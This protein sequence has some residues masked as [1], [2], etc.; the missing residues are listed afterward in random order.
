[1]KRDHS[2]ALQSALDTA[3]RPLAGD[4]DLDPIIER[5]GDRRLV[6]L[7]EASHGTSEFY[8]WRARLTKRLIEEK[9]FDF[10]AAEGDWPDCWEV[11]RYVRDMPGAGRSAQDVLHAFHRWPT[12]MWANR[13]VVEF[14]E[15]L[16]T[17][18]DG[19]P[20]DRR[21]GFFGLDVYSLWDSMEAVLG[22]LEGVDPDAAERARNAYGCFD[23]YSEDVQEYAFAAQYVPTR[24]EE[25]VVSILGELRAK[26]TRYLAEAMSATAPRYPAASSSLHADLARCN[27][28]C[29]AV[30]C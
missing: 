24:C 25:E 2:D 22:Y 20:R 7:G 1:M 27:A 10:V 12:W 30:N 16:R 9:G 3:W 29:R 8:T 4:A 19:R 26:A 23:P 21:A 18:N 17:F 15:W 28:N 13:E 11:N 14:A 5:I 6:L